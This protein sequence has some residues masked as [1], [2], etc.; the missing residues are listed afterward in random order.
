MD[1]KRFTFHKR[2]KIDYLYNDDFD[3][4]SWSIN[5]G[6]RRWVRFIY[7]KVIVMKFVLGIFLLICA[8]A[9]GYYGTVSYQEGNYKWAYFD[10][11]LAVICA[12][13]GVVDIICAVRG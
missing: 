2:R 13:I 5:N 10:F 1:C 6:L 12:I 11:C 4:A 9:D 3:L 8:I 7:R